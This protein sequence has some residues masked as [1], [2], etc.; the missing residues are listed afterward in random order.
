MFPGTNL[1]PGLNPNGI[2]PPNGVNNNGISTNSPT[3]PT[4][5]NS[6]TSNNTINNNPSFTK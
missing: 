2:Y 1:V 4:N 6:S 5:I 3:L